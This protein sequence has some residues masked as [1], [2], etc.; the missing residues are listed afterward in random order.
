MRSESFSEF[1]I[2]WYS[3]I[4]VYLYSEAAPSKLVRSF[5]Q[6]L[7]YFQKCMPSCIHKVLQNLLINCL[8]VHYFLLILH[9]S[10]FFSAT[11]YR[12]Y[13]G[14]KTPASLDDRPVDVTHLV[15]VIHG[16]GQK[17]DKD[18]IIRNTCTSVQL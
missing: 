8:L 5:T 13:R 2:D 9:T 16:I 18:R 17:M 7:G 11:G 4:E 10:Y 14:Y 6:K 1:R 15:F 3:P 12:L